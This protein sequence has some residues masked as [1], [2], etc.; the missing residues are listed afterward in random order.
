MSEHEI[1]NDGAMFV[2]AVVILLS[3]LVVCGVIASL[4]EGRSR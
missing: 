1:A 4:K 3:A 2:A